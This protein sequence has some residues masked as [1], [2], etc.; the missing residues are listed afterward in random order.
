MANAFSTSDIKFFE[1]LIVGFDNANVVAKNTAIYS[2]N[3]EMMEQSDLTVWRPQPFHST[4]STGL[5]V[6]SAY[7]DLTQLVVPSTL[8]ATD[9]VNDAFTMNA[10]ELNDPQRR[11]R[12]A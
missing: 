6:S 2:P 9:I 11:R 7:K 3:M 10:I 1:D 12:K 5:D 8:A 4:L